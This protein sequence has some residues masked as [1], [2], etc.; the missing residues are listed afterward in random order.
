MTEPSTGP[1]TRPSYVVLLPVKP[2]ARGKSRLE[3]DS[4][5]RRDL[6]AAFALDTA[7][8]CLAADQIV[9]VLAIPSDA[10]FADDLRSAGCETIPDGVAGD[11]KESLRQA[12]AEARRRRPDTVPVAVCAD[13]P[14]LR[15][16]DLNAALRDA[17][18][19]VAFVTDG[20]GTGTTLYTAPYESFD[21]QFGFRSRAAHRDAGARE[22]GGDLA[23]L[24][25]DVD[26][27]DALVQA[28]HLGV[29]AHTR[30]VLLG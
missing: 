19:D 21:P 12:A 8:A 26:D 7:Q 4:R 28:E 1:L 15:P 18:G 27:R 11:L 6:A 3:V 14:A 30:L 24:R 25:R 29:G 17:D 9:S 2:P 10:R 13:L 20:D 23:T 16:A 22:I 5:R